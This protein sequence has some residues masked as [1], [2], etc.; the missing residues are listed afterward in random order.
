MTL[1]RHA[2]PPV[3]RL[4]DP[5]RPRM[6]QR[7]S[8]GGSIEGSPFFWRNPQ[9]VLHRGPM[10]ASSGEDAL[11]SGGGSGATDAVINHFRPVE[12]LLVAIYC[13]SVRKGLWNSR[14]LG[15]PS[16]CWRR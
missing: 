5:L 7:L 2:L 16:S 12:R 4:L 11:G 10:S 6:T 1:P 8:Q 13:T 9:L 3:P 14:S 15:S